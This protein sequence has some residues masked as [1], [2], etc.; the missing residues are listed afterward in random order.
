MQQMI[1]DASQKF[2]TENFKNTTDLPKTLTKN[3]SQN[4]PI[5][6]N[7]NAYH[8]SLLQSITN[9]QIKGSFI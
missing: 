7:L 1:S 6:F 3:L 9:T 4:N 8:K 5:V 2:L